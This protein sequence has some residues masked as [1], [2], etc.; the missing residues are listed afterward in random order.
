MHIWTNE[1]NILIK[2][3]PFLPEFGKSSLQFRKVALKY[4]LKYRAGR[5]ALDQEAALCLKGTK[6]CSSCYGTASIFV[7]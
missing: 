2:K 4:I 7:C 6:P 1:W 3:G 5:F